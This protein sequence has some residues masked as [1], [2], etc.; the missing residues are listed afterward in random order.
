[1]PNTAVQSDVHGLLT[2]SVLSLEQTSL[3]LEPPNALLTPHFYLRLLLA[4]V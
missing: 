2:Q 3:R 4:L 1:M